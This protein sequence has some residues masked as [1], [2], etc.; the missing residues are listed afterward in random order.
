MKVGHPDVRSPLAGLRFG[1]VLHRLAQAGWPT[2]V[3]LLAAACGVAMLA[4][5]WHYD[6]QA[7][8]LRSPEA[9]L[10]EPNNPAD[11][12]QFARATEALFTVP[13]DSSHIDDLSRLFKLAKA[14]GVHIGTVEYRQEQSPSLQVLVRTLDIRIHEDYPKLK[15]FVAELLGAM[16]HVSLQEIR[17]DRKDAV[18]LQGQVL[19]KL[20]FV[21][22]VSG[23]TPTP[24]KTQP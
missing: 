14:K 15:G 12:R 13:E 17:V 9:V 8:R 22:Q 7:R 23:T 24:I 3:G 16:P 5:A 10:G 4:A 6:L 21:Y 1:A 20:A 18:T 11:T 19:L 2:L